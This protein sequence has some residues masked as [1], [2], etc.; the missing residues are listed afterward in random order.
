MRKLFYISAN[1]RSEKGVTLVYVAILIVVF[2]GMTAL[3]VDI[4]YLMVSRNELQNA[5]DAAA[6][7]G[8]RRLGE[9]YN[10]SVSP[11]STNV[12]TV[13][14]ATASQ[15]KATGLKL[16]AD[17]VLASYGNWDPASAPNNIPFPSNATYPD[18][19]KATVKRTAGITGGAVETFF[20]PIF[21]LIDPSFEDKRPVEATAC[22]AI[23]GICTETPGLPLGIG[24][25]WFTNIGAN[26]G[27]TQIALNKTNESCAG[28]TNLSTTENYDHKDVQDMLD[29]TKKIPKVKAGDI[30]PFNGGVTQQVVD[31]LDALFK[32]EATGTPPT[33]TTGVVVFEDFGICGNPNEKLK[34]LGF[35]TVKITGV[36]LTGSNKG[37]Q[38]EVQ[39]NIAE[40][41]RGG[42]FYAG[43]YG[44]IPGLVQ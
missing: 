18:A 23:S 12:L 17:N 6:L 8:A 30:V 32:R 14:Q 15:N 21:K 40:Q 38:G 11:V 7:A 37:P 27:C 24:R 44:V 20:A 41:E 16:E 31:A 19:V 39:C 10:L 2:L 13:A 33:W 3:A 1:L 9:N 34:I 35:A 36:I 5:A 29:G 4:G 42:C 43:T 25:S 22:A 26:K 28:W